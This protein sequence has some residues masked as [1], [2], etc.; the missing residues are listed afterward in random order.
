M[1]YKPKGINVIVGTRGRKIPKRIY[2]TVRKARVIAGIFAKSGL[3]VLLLLCYLS[4]DSG[5]VK[6]WEITFWF[7]FIFFF[8]LFLIIGYIVQMEKRF[9]EGYYGR[10]RES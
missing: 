8:V 10:D 2:E 3:G 9:T 7:G 6:M 4:W 5:L 1:E